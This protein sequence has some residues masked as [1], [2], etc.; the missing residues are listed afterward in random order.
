MRS[1]TRSIACAVAAGLL[2]FFVSLARADEGMWTLHNFP[3]AALKQKYGTDVSAAWLDHVRLSTVRLQNCTASF[4]SANGLLLT[5]HHCAV[6]SPR[7]ATKN[8]AAV[9]KS[10]MF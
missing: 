2:A 5:N 7:A 9:R 1:L 3:A 8:C 4:V 6:F 10:P